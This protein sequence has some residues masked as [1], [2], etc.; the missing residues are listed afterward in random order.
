MHLRTI[1]DLLKSLKS[2]RFFV[3]VFFC[4]YVQMLPDENDYQIAEEVSSNF[5]MMKKGELQSENSVLYG[6]SLLWREVINRNHQEVIFYS[7]QKDYSKLAGVLCNLLRKNTVLGMTYPDS[8]NVPQSKIYRN[9]YAKLRIARSLYGYNKKLCQ[10]DSVKHRAGLM[11]GLD[12]GLGNPIVVDFC[13]VKIDFESIYYG[14]ILRDMVS[15]ISLEEMRGSH[16]LELG[17]GIGLLSILLMK[18][19]ENVEYTYVDLPE[20]LVLAMYMVKKAFPDAIVNIGLPSVHK[21]KNTSNHVFNFVPYYRMNEVK[22][23]EIDIAIN[24]FSLPE[25]N[26]ESAQAYLEQIDGVLKK[27]GVLF[28]INRENS[29]KSKGYAKFDM[30]GMRQLI[31]DCGRFE[32]KDSVEPSESY[33][34]NNDYVYLEENIEIATYMRIVHEG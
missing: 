7:E 13:G 11:Y 28:S 1:N 33:S 6:P 17:S 16:I 12:L 26:T 5:I 3:E 21:E 4:K 14:M 18:Q 9:I 19:V 20:N 24:I 30:T 10:R 2:Y 27:N 32:K 15:L 29:I 8:Y 22:R 31:K 23:S 25:M 34:I